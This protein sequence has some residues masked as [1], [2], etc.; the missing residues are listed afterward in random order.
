MERLVLT[1]RVAREN[2]GY[3][4]RVDQLPLEGAGDSVRQAQDE[5]IQ[6]MRAWIQVH[7][8]SDSLG[9]VLAQAGFQGVEEET[10]LELEFVGEQGEAK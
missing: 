6:A 9:E 5:L 1:A 2:G 7:D 8:G 3:V 10:E 4:A